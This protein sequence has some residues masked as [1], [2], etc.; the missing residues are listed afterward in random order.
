M[1]VK[2]INKPL[3]ILNKKLVNAK[4]LF[5]VV[6]GSHAYGTN[7]E[8]S[9]IDYSGIYVQSTEDILG[10][11]YKEQV[12]DDKNDIVL[13]E[14]RRFLELVRTNNPNILELL[15]T[16][17]D[18]ILYKDPIFDLI[19][20]NK[21]KLV[22]KKCSNSFGGYAITQIK[23]AKGLNKKQNWEKDKISKKDLLD[24]C[25]VISDGKSIPW[26]KFNESKLYDE[27][28]IGAVSIPNARDTYALYYDKTAYMLHSEDIDEKTRETYKKVLKEAGK[29]MGLG[30]KGIIKVGSVFKECD[31]TIKERNHENLTNDEIIEYG[32]VGQ[33]NIKENYGI[34]NQLR[35][36]SVPKGE[37][38]FATIIYNKDGYSEHCK[39][40]KE[41]QEWLEKR[42]IQRYVDVK[43]HNQQ[44]DGKNMMHCARLLDM[45]IE[46]AKGE[47]I[48]VRRRNKEELLDIRKGKV[49]LNSLIDQY[50]EKI[51][52]IEK[53]FKESNLPDEV[54]FKLL[55]DI[56]IKIRKKFL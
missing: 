24:F 14:I 30:Y 27:K 31:G 50:E 3:E 16:P 11:N 19:L 2:D 45:C 36:S 54:D 53:L 49:D 42:N 56:L 44:I 22:T 25:Y 26:K 6:R 40:Y 23:K 33:K 12:N 18:C 7:I 38:S 48:N 39:D 41:Y 8:T 17:E 10:F 34:S 35:L 47:G 4:P 55:E 32:L 5:I 20:E 52:Y 46:I 51:I 29:P 15:N 28:F 1:E 13:Y 21:D 43:N 9:D 37:K